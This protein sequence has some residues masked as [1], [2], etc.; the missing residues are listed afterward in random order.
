MKNNSLY[1]LLGESGRLCRTAV[2]LPVLMLAACSQDESAHD[3][4]STLRHTTLQVASL[5]TDDGAATRATTDYPTDRHIGFFVKENTASGYAAL[6]NSD[7]IYSADRK[8]WLP[9]PD[10]IWLN[11]NKADISVYAPYDAAHGKDG[12]LKLAPCHRLKDG[13]KDISFT[14][15][16]ADNKTAPQAL[17]LTH[18]YAR[19]TISVTRD[20]SYTNE[21]TFNGVAMKGNDIY[22]DA[23]FKPFDAA[24]SR[25]AY[26]SDKEFTLAV[27]PPVSITA[28]S[29]SAVFDLLLIPSALSAD[30]TLQ[31]I[32]G[33]DEKF[34]AVIP[35]AKF[36]NALKEGKQYQVNV[37]LKGVILEV[38]SVMITDWDAE[39]IADEQEPPFID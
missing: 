39:I 11:N 3:N 20:V 31:L 23:S 21:V 19:L 17:T 5:S 35:R 22:K 12:M 8:L 16:T 32:S 26:G 10:S 34:T 4:G 18:V 6:H 15:F 7:G 9:T 13:S 27:N 36:G 1:N 37:K 33:G 24:A 38:V 2:I 28:A 30:V 29:P 25:Y 14:T